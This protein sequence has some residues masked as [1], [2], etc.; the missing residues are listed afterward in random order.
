MVMV[1]GPSGSG[2][3]SLIRAGLLPALINKPEA[4]HLLSYSAFDLAEKGYHSLLTT[5]GGMLLDL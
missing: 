4:L 2:K 1:L 3:T 5:L